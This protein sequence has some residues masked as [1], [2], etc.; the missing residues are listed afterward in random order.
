M[1]E[2]ID[3]RPFGAF[4]YTPP[5]PKPIAIFRSPDG[6]YFEI[7]V[8][9]ERVGASRRGVSEWVDRFRKAFPDDDKTFVQAGINGTW[10]CNL[11]RIDRVLLSQPRSGRAAR[12]ALERL[13]DEW[14]TSASR[15]KYLKT[16]APLIALTDGDLAPQAASRGCEA[17]DGD[18]RSTAPTLERPTGA[19]PST[20]GG[21]K[22]SRL[23]AEYALP[24][25]SDVN[26][27][28]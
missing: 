5:T 13:A 22:R 19:E 8:F 18:V 10:Y 4:Q 2:E 11:E 28:I 9:F 25:A 26:I 27:T 7:R 14:K 3:L 17:P 15:A 12:F 1:K 21:S 20:S 23:N 24:D 6:V 16:N